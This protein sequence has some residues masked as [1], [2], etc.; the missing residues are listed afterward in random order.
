MV[1]TYTREGGSTAEMTGVFSLRGACGA[2]EVGSLGVADGC[3][4][5]LLSGERAD[6]VLGYVS[7]R[8][9]PMILAKP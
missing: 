2:A 5:E 3:Y 4:R 1:C 9:E 8:G 7:C 6:V